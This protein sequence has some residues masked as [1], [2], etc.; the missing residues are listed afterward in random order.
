MRFRHRKPELRSPKTGRTPS[1]LFS[2]DRRRPIPTL[3]HAPRHGG[4]RGDL[5]TQD[6]GAAGI[7]PGCLKMPAAQLPVFVN[8]FTI[9][10][11]WPTP[12]GAA[13]AKKEWA[14]EA[15]TLLG[16]APSLE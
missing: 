11:R 7:L 14:A 6:L 10:A 9:G 8:S 2:C 12:G 5:F 1:P 3:G 16:G 15:T 13:Q 4:G